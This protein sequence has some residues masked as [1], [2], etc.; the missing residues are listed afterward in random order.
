MCCPVNPDFA[1]PLMIPL[2]GDIIII[3]KMSFHLGIKIVQSR[4]TVD[5]AQKYRFVLALEN[6][7][8]GR[9]SSATRRIDATQTTLTDIVP[10][11]D[12]R[13][14]EAPFVNG[15]ILRVVIKGFFPFGEMKGLE[16]IAGPRARAEG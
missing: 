2:N 4:I 14:G 10:P 1:S 3:P 13:E 7:I 15:S 11:K 16:P 12:I 5:R 8:N 9:T 6:C